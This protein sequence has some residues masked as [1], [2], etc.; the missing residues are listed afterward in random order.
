MS[1]VEKIDLSERVILDPDRLVHLCVSLGESVTESLVTA[2]IGDI[3]KGMQ[4]VEQVHLDHGLPE[5]VNTIG[6]LGSVA[7]HIGLVSFAQVACDVKECAEADDYVA[8]S[9]TLARLHRIANKSETALVDLEN[10]L[11]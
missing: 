11:L 10:M 6:R 1:A 9:A 5:L 4:E 7:R 8:F 2:S 3:A